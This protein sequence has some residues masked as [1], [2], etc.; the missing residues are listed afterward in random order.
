MAFRIRKEESV[1]KGLRR[2]LN[3][4]TTSAI[5]VL[6]SNAQSDEA[7][8][9]A[10]TSIKKLRAVLGMIR[11]DVPDVA[12]HDLERLRRAGR[13]L[14]PMRDADALLETARDLCRRYPGALS[15]R[16]CAEF[17]RRLATRKQHANRTAS[18]DQTQ[19]KA[20]K[21]LRGLRKSAKDWDLKT[22]R[23][24]RIAKRLE[25]SY[26]SARKA[27]AQAQKKQQA[28]DFH[29][30]RKRSKDLWYRLRLFEEL[31][32]TLRREIADLKRLETWLGEDHNLLVLRTQVVGDRALQQ[33]RPAVAAV[34]SRAEHRQTQLRRSALSLGARLFRRKP[35]LY[36]RHIRR[37]W[38]ASKARPRKPVTARSRHSSR[39]PRQD[40]RRAA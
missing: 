40:A 2:I 36:V 30:W 4:E 20:A 22:A 12:N 29:Q 8:H 33:D 38:R 17:R 26:R 34:T 1:K 6:T 32:P 39:A 27:M 13:L 7:V 15:E 21:T 14:S 23:F 5:E 18:R 16:T 9:E 28:S 11:K 19:R 25:E 10:R 35:R 37:A 24:A 31:M 3:K